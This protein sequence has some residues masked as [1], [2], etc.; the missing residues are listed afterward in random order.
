MS[1]SGPGASRQGDGDAPAT[2]DA[3]AVA[4]RVA[5]PGWDAETTRAPSASEAAAAERPSVLAAVTV[6]GGS[7]AGATKVADG[8]G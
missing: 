5:G 8:T 6:V 7:T 4:P 1:S 3:S 2:A